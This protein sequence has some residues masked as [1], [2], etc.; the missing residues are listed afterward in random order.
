M[1]DSYAGAAN[2]IPFNAI[3]VRGSVARIR[4]CAT[5]A[6]RFGRSVPNRPVWRD[7]ANGGSGRA[8]EVEMESACAP[9]GFAP[10]GVRK[11]CGGIF[12]TQQ[13]GVQP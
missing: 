3:P 13:Q 9:R 5:R 2:A 7:S 6:I 11:R 4:Q 8:D 1:K 12:N 10:G